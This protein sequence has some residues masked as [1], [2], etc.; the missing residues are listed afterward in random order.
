PGIVSTGEANEMDPAF[1]PDMSEFYFVKGYT[2]QIIRRNENSWGE[3]E[4]ASFSGKFPDFEAF[5]THDGGRLYFISRRPPENWES[6]YVERT[7]PA[8]WGEA[9]LLGEK[10]K[11]GFYPTLTEKGNVYVTA[12]WHNGRPFHLYYS[13]DMGEN[14]YSELEKLPEEINENGAF[15]SCISPD[16]SFIIFG[17]A[18][19]PDGYGGNDLYI[20]FRDE[21]GSWSKAK[22]LG[23]GINTEHHDSRPVLS[24]DGRFFFFSS[25]KYG[26]NDIFWVDT[27]I[28][29]R[30]KK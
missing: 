29:N 19:Q 10:F 25:N 16:E 23:E 13:R 7:G 30:L 1:Y 17:K 15:E 18:D 9:K 21:D 12:F 3:P 20:S 14:G 22:N 5:I 26:T 8:S 6:Y 27:K 11:G 28:F 4:T 2:Y 24:H